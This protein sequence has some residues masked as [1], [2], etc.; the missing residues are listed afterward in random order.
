MYLGVLLLWL[1][2]PPSEEVRK[3]VDTALTTPPEIA[4]DAL[5]RIASSSAVT[6]RTYSIELLNRATALAASAV[7]PFRRVGV[8]GAAQATD[9]DASSLSRALAPGLDG[10][11]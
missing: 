1:A 9:T 2:P 6:D 7:H 5:I 4:A 3:L 11:S 10:L 8:V